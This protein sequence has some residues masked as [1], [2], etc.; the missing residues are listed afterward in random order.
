MKAVNDLEGEYM[1]QECQSVSPIDQNTVV[2]YSNS[3]G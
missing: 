1:G 3:A 2:Q